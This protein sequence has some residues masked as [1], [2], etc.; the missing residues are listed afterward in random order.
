[1]VSM[2]LK[3]MDEIRKEKSCKIIH[4]KIHFCVPGSYIQFRP[5]SYTDESH[6]ASRNTE[7]HL[8]EPFSIADPKV[9]LNSSLALSYY[10]DSL[11]KYLIQS[12][13]IS[14]GQINDGFYSKSNY[15][16]W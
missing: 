3:V 5:L 11:D 9:Y 8:N 4:W 6:D 7:A 1:M 10:G 12:F 13:N 2:A 16:T 14:F 15:T